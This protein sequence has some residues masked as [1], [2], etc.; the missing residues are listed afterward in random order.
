MK[1]V[2][3]LIMMAAVAGC[4]VTGCSKKTYYQVYQTQPVNSEAVQPK[5]GNMVHDGSDCTVSYNFFAEEGNAGYW[6]TNNTDSVIFISLSESFF[7]LNGTAYDHFQARR[8]TTTSSQTQQSSTQSGKSKKRNKRSTVATQGTSQTSTQA[9]AIEERGMVIVP[10][11]ASKYVVC[12]YRINT[13]KLELCGVKDTPG[14][15]KPAGTTYT[16][17][18]SPI[19]FANYITYTVGNGNKKHVDD[20]FFVQEIINVNRRAMT[21]N[22]RVKD[23]CGKNTGEKMEQMRYATPDRFYVKYKK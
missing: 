1:K 16:N 21:E 9:T 5:D 14:R 2:N 20:R 4:V 11:H 3:I 8:W 19:L 6:F 17:E 13:A 22:V 23:A 12:E 7:I 10:P 15:N 18:N